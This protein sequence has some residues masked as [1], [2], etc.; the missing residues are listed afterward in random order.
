MP[1]VLSGSQGIS[2]NG[3]NYLAPNDS[4]YI[5]QPGIPA[6]WARGS[7]DISRS[8]AATP[9]KLVCNVLINGS[10]SGSHYNTTTARFTAPVAGYYQF[11][12]SSATTT[13]TSS[14]PALL[15]YKNGSNLTE[16]SINYSGASFTQFGGMAVV[17]AVAGDFFEPYINNYNSTSFTV[18]LVRTRFSGHFL[19]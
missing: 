14:G 11:F 13:P 9:V 5:T 1:L 2:S 18:D 7:V 19:G 12:I 17:P 8:G 4:G 10:N 6:F 15:L 3:V 16:V